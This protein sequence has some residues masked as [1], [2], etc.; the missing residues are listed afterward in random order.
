M[1]LRAKISPTW[2]TAAE[3]QPWSL[4]PE[5]L[6]MDHAAFGFQQHR[7]VKREFR[8]IGFILNIPRPTNRYLQSFIA[9]KM[10]TVRKGAACK[11]RWREASKP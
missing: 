11:L 2:I 3:D 8:I 4:Y 6:L 5:C 10:T 9:K 1:R 7:R